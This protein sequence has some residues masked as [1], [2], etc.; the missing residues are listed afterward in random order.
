MRYLNRLILK[1]ISETYEEVREKRGLNRIVH[2]DTAKL[3][4]IDSKQ[5]AKLSRVSHVWKTGDRFYKL[6]NKHY[7]DPKKWWVIA[8][9]NKRPTEAH[10]QL[11]DLIFI[12]QP[13][14]TVLRY[15]GV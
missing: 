4:H 7:G 12:P 6:A 14:E 1:N 11:G 15:L 2:Y 3:K 8:W 13:L 5:I 9:Y 10:V